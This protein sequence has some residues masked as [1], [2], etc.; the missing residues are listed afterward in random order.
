MAVTIY[1]VSE[2]P[3]FRPSAGILT[4]A[5]GLGMLIWYGWH[6]RGAVASDIRNFPA[7][8]RSFPLVTIAFAVFKMVAYVS[9]G[10]LFALMV[11]VPVRNLWLGRVVTGVP[12]SVSSVTKGRRVLLSI[13]VNGGIITL[14]GAG[15][16][17]PLLQ[18]SV[19]C[20][21]RLRLTIG[22]FDSLLK[23]EKL[24]ERTEG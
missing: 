13:Q 6:I 15:G 17:E 16:L 24:T 22:A 19:T 1:D 14:R 12:H 9:F 20:G 11:Y 8:Y 10:V 18:D 2:Q 21:D 5:L 23:I 4:F 3:R 7:S